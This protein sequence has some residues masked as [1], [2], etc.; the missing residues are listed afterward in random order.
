MSRCIFELSSERRIPG[1]W[2]KPKSPSITLPKAKKNS[3]KDQKLP[4]S[5]DSQPNSS[6]LKAFG[7]VMQDL[8][9]VHEYETIILT[10]REEYD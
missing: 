10:R 3:P 5:G 6:H 1:L 8:P 9:K 4:L 2:I 7:K